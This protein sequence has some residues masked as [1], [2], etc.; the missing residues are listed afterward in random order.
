MSE[1]YG[2]SLLWPAKHIF[3]MSFQKTSLNENVETTTKKAALRTLKTQRQKHATTRNRARNTETLVAEDRGGIRKDAQRASSAARETQIKPRDHP[4]S[5]GTAETKNAGTP[6][7][8]R[9]W[10]RQG[11]SDS[12]EGRVEQRSPSRQQPGSFL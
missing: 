11:R 8:G 5:I 7:C 1:T 12:A 4:P 6:K 10:I 2:R 9:G 3:R